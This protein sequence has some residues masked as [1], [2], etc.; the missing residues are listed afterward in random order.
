[1]SLDEARGAGGLSDDNGAPKRLTAA[2]KGPER[3]TKLSRASG[4]ILGFEST[5]EDIPNDCA[6]WVRSFADRSG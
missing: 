6:G 2:S 4:R 3:S 5:V 1:M